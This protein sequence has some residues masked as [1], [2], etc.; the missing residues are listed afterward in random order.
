MYSK[1][2]GLER[3]LQVLEVSA[4]EYSYRAIL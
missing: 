1:V 3:E 2:S 4:T